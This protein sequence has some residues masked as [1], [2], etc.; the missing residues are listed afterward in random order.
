[1]VVQ[2][3]EGAVIRGRKGAGGVCIKKTT[4]AMVVGIY[5]EGTQPGDVNMVVENL[6]DYLI[7]ELLSRV[8][9]AKE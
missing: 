9:P 8:R 2:G 5:T 7:G 4:T 3:D 1:M 6:G